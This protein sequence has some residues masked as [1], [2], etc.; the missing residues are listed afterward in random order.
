MMHADR[1]IAGFKTAPEEVSL[2]PAHN[3]LAPTYE[4]AIIKHEIAF[5]FESMVF[6]SV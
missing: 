1:P 5:S 2:F 6:S 4:A 3:D